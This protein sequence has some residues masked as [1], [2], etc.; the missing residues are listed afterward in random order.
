MM[1]EYA[2]DA[3]SDEIVITDVNYEDIIR[4]HKDGDIKAI[5]KVRIED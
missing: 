2:L 1:L 5:F 3:K 4:H